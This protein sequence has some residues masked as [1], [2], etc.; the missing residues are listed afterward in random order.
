MRA[1]KN[2]HQRPKFNLNNEPNLPHTTVPLIKKCTNKKCL[3]NLC[4][5]VGSQLPVLEVAHAHVLHGGG[6]LGGPRVG[7]NRFCLVA[8][9]HG[10]GRVLVVVAQRHV[11]VRQYRAIF[12]LRRGGGG[13]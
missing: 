10:A 9:C 12:L 1:K 13:G 11:H 4:V 5:L 8:N 6:E 3:I 7:K 2:H